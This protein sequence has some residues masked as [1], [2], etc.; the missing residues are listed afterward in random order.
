M[1][2]AFRALWFPRRGNS[3]EEYEDAFAADEQAERYALAD[4][5]SESP[6]A[7]LWAG[8]LVDDFVR[9]DRDPAEWTASLPPLQDRFDA[10]VRGR[11][12]PWYGEVQREQGAFA[13][14]LG[15]VVRDCGHPT[16][17]WQ[18]VAVGDTC[19]FHTRGT[20]M[21][22]A[23]PLDRAEQFSNVPRLV[24]SRP[25]PETSWENRVLND[26]RGGLRGDRLWL[27]TDALAHWCL[28]EHEAGRNPWTEMESFLHTEDERFACWTEELRDTRGLTNDDVTLLCIQL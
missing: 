5:A 6:F 12:L 3:P 28:A 14:M 21:I 18:A 16:P 25:S 4:G 24:G 22:R 11:P 13:T 2:A 20:E 7:R 1:P 10:D 19:L 17:S 15:L 23:F 27:L 9:H 26:R 8:M